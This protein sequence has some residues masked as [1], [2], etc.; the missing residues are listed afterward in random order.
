MIGKEAEKLAVTY[1]RSVYPSADIDA[2]SK[3]VGGHRNGANLGHAGPIND[4]M[5]RRVMEF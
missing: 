4:V 5:L 1:L 2:C 3:G